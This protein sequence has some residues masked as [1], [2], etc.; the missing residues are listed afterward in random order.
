MTPRTKATEA[1]P[2]SKGLLRPE[3]FADHVRFG[4][5]LPE[6][7]AAA[8]VERIWS[9]NWSLPAGVAHTTQLIPHPSVSL[10][11]E[12]GQLNRDGSQGD[13]V[14]LT[15]VVSGRFDVTIAGAGGTVGVKFRPGGFTA[16]SGVA[17]DQLTDR[18]LP[19]GE[20]L[21]ATDALRDLALDAATAADA[22][23]GHLIRHAENAEPIP[24]PVGRALAMVLSVDVT[25]V[26]ELA[27]R[28]GCSVRTLQR[29]LRRHVGVGPKWLIR[30]QRMHD[31]VAALDAGSSE[32]LAEL[33]ARL[34]WY[35]QSQFARDFTRL[36]GVPPATYRDR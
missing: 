13:G 9:T 20:L 14:Y 33:A 8:W 36:V 24:D 26:D 22:L 4:E 5:V 12:R 1:L 15:G 27:R 16:W 17:A 25:R 11:V 10:T 30:R 35:D 32:S 3:E 34:G 29:L 2:A 31:A 19:A 7:P 28:C 23:C 21:A 18:V 6:G